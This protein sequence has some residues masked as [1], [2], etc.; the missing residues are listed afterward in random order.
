[1]FSLEQYPLKFKTNG[2]E[3]YMSE[4]TVNFHYGK[5]LDTYIKN[6]NGLITGT[7]YEKMTLREIVSE[8]AKDEN[9]KKIFNNAGQVFNHD[10]FFGGMAK[11]SKAECPKRIVDE[12]GSREK[13]IEEFKAAAMV[14]FGSGWAWLVIDNEKLKIITT[15]NAD[16]PIAHGLKPVLAL[17]VWEHSYYLDY[18]NKRGDFVDAFLNHL[19]DWDFVANNI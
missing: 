7:K 6:L 8:S 11:D 14:V 19:V 12:F 10:F 18:Q 4:S 3:P 16:N 1:M 5:H 15:A 13:F 2:L 9:A 17:D